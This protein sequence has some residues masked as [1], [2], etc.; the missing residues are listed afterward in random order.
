[1]GQAL[2]SNELLPGKRDARV[3][4]YILTRLGMAMA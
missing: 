1:M 4:L 3:S 2:R